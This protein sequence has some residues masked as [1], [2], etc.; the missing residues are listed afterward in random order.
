MLLS[1][2]ASGYI[3]VQVITEV[4]LGTF[5]LAELLPELKEFLQAKGASQKVF[6]IIDQ[7]IIFLFV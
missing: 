3:F 1:Q 4:M 5:T 2:H 7:V 6:E